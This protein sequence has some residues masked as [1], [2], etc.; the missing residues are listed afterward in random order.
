M[1]AT[2]ETYEG[3]AFA[4]FIHSEV[5]GSMVLLFATIVALGWANSPWA[6]SYFALEQTY[7]G[8]SWGESVFKMSLGHW[9]GDGLMVIFFFVVG[10][11]IKREVV[12]GQ[13]SSLERAILPV[14]AAVGG[15]LVPALLY[16]VFNVG[17]PSANG[18][19]V[20]MAT[21]IAFALG[22]LALFGKRVPIGLKVFLT[23][24]AIADDLGAVIVIAVFYTEQIS[25][26]G[27]GVA[28]LF[29]GLIFLS[30][31]LGLRQTWIYLIMMLMVWVGVLASGIHA[32][33][34]GVLL[35]LL[36]PVRAQLAPGEF[37]ERV[38][39]NIGNL[40][41]RD[42]TKESMI[43]DKEQTNALDDLY[44]AA[45][46]MRPVG[47]AL[48]NGLHPIQAFLILPLFA[49][50]KAGI[51]LG[52]ETTGA[53]PSLASLGVICGLVLGKPIGVLLFSWLAIRSGRASLPEGVTSLQL[54]GAG[55]LAGVGFTMSIFISEL[56]FGYGEALGEVK[57]G[58][59]VASLLAGVTGYIVLKVAFAKTPET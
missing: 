36:I 56:A 43:D 54:L 14:S 31:Q 27:L 11:E 7:V 57:L 1:A 17:S 39:R 30:V 6:A 40:E 32:T 3:S 46:D 42:L 44:L 24:L 51:P 2:E 26:M 15:M 59:L 9:I 52:P 33:I 34:A 38:R 19:G 23:A 28:G 58:I 10:L 13:L 47:F 12:V 35:A 8:V 21:D 50:F 22:I 16:S 5:A 29:L 41:S 53:F 18:W 45:N 20:P 4:R 49:L 55:C 25:F 48:E 37:F